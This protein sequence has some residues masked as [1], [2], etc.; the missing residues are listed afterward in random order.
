MMYTTVSALKE[1]LCT[2]AILPSSLIQKKHLLK[3][4]SL[5]FPDTFVYDQLWA[6]SV[7]RVSGSEEVFLSAISGS[8]LLY[9]A[10]IY[11]AERTR[12]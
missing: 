8:E 7:A 3:V 4:F 2:C 9:M 12:F 6:S 1:M 11:F 10:S 5:Y